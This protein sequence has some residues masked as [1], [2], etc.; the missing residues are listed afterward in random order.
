MSL[1]IFFEHFDHLAD[2]PNRLQ[3][4]RELILQLAVQ[5]KLVPQDP[6]DEPASVQLERIRLKKEDQNKQRRLWNAEQQAHDVPF[7]LPHNWKW[8]KLGE[9][10]KIVGGGTPRTDNPAYYS[11]NGVPWLTP[12][13]LYQLKG[14]YIGRG[15]RDIS[16]L[17][18]R[19]SSAQLMP[20]G[21]VLFSS[22]APIGYVAIAANDLA[23]NQG[24]KSCVPFILQMNEYIYYF[25]KYSAK[26]IEANA[27]GTTFKEVS[28]K[29]VS[30]ILIPLPPLAEQRRIVAK[31]DQ[32]IALCDE[33]ESRQQQRREARLRLNDVALDNLLAAHDPDDFATHWQRLRDNFDLL[34]DM[35]DTVGKLRQA[36]L[37]LAVQGKLVPQDPNDES[38][39]IL[40]D[41][42]RAAKERLI[43]EGKLKKEKSL[44]TIVEVQLPFELPSGWEWVRI[45]EIYQVSGGIQKTPARRPVSNYYPYLRVANVY[46]GKLELTDMEYFELF[47][48]ELERWRLE[49]GDLLVVEGNGSETEIGRCAEWGG[50][51]EYCVHQNHLIRCRPISHSG[52]QFTLLSL[53]S[54]FGM[55]QMKRLA[56]TTS[57]LYN[58]SV[59]KIRNIVVPLPPKAEQRRIL[60]KVAQLMVLCDELEAKLKQ[61]QAASEALMEAVVR[62][63]MEQ[64][65]TAV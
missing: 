39:S 15:K 49:P 55:A 4:L 26:A 19:E 10:G 31:V 6:N 51:I 50:E 59:G 16:E 53:N 57:G 11:L 21:T 27:A 13:D 58:L 33:L 37:Q 23:T 43:A 35:P 63:V 28:G 41:N 3:K 56:I 42:I 1:D 12:A 38:A 14:K 36:I 54:P 29:D 65:V 30:E 48:G 22:R 47:E 40:L 7:E 20:V 25:L 8:M 18:L 24:F 61:A 52:S 45:D 32:L 34:Y 46:R 44:Q 2:A 17:G 62:Q 5:G 60:I 64:D 9:V